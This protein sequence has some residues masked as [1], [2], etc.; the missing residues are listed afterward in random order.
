M[1]DAFI[2]GFLNVFHPEPLVLVFLAVVIA[3]I[4]GV[5][6][7]LGAMFGMSLLLPF[8]Y[9]MDPFLALQC[10]V[11][12]G[13]VAM[14]GGS[15]TAVLLNIPGTAANLATCI[16]GYPMTQKGE[17]GR[18]IGA[19]LMASGTGGF[20]GVALSFITIPV[21]IPAVLAMRM[22][23]TFFLVVMGISFIAALESEGGQ[24]KG[25]IS[26]ALGLLMGFVGFQAL[27]GLSRFGFGTTY[28][29]EGLPV[30]PM[31]LGLFAGAELIDLAVSGET[32][33]KTEAAATP[34]RQMLQGAG[35]VFRNAWLWFRSCVVGYIIGVVP[36]IGATGAM[37][38]AYGQGKQ[39]SKHPEKFG[40][41]CIEGVIAPESANNACFGGD[42]LTTLSFGIPGGPP[43]ALLL[44]GFL[45]VGI[46]PGPQLLTN[47][48]ELS[49]TLFWT[50]AFANI[51]AA[52]I[53]IPAIPYLVRVARIRPDYLLVSVATLIFIGAFTARLEILDL[54]VLLVFTALGVLMKR[55]GFSRPAFLL[56]FVLA[57]EFEKYFWLALKLQGPLFFLR[58]ISLVLIALTIGILSFDKIRVGVAW[59]LKTRGG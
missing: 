44:A 58:P 37:F 22:A 53:C 4:I 10:M 21:V 20:L 18:A 2:Q 8:T 17:A 47:Y 41:G 9:G 30:I 46:Q 56:G 59:L 6:P 31:V 16:D 34:W 27:T 36:G 24:I 5:L 15:I 48:P 13:A 29:Y 54:V 38:I 23:E 32:I 40:K 43:Q 52:L 11:S 55:F 26:G 42:L 50:V 28:L 12:V 14:T 33:A 35:D 1:F 25:L 57:V 7:G 19:S 45:V 39:T 51:M 49:F 3:V